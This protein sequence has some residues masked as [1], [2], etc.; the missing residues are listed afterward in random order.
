MTTALGSTPPSVDPSEE[1]GR[2]VTPGKIAAVVASLAILLFWIFVFAK[3][4]SYH[5]PGYLEDRTFPKAAEKICASYTPQLEAI[6]LAQTATTSTERA[7][8]VDEVTAILTERRDELRTVVPDTDDAR[9]IDEWLDDWSAN[10]ADRQAYADELRV[11]PAAEFL[12]SV[13]GESSQMSKVLDKFAKD[14]EMGSC[15]TSDDVG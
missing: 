3:G 8:L 1:D 11:N 9:F 12:E 15:T 7:D 14:N 6:P 10:F 5:P 4:G 13:K 2:R